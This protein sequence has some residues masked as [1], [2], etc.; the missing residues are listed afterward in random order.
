MLSCGKSK[1]PSQLDGSFEQSKHMLKLMGKKI[2]E[3]S[4]MKTGLK[5]F[6]N[7]NGAEQ[8]AHLQNLINTF[9]LLAGSSKTCLKRPLKIDKI[10]VSKDRW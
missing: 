9:C 8:P 6:L 1:E 4:H 10:K 5:S 2:F 3:P 7:N